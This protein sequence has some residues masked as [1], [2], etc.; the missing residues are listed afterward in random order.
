MVFFY[1][2]RKLIEINSK[3]VYRLEINIYVMWGGENRESSFLFLVDEKVVIELD[4]E[5]FIMFVGEIRIIDGEDKVFR[6]RN[7]LFVL[8]WGWSK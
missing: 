2:Y 4:E 7:I 5:V 3:I 1:S 6:V 8:D